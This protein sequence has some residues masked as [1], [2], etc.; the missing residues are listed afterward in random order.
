MRRPA[1]R[2][3]LRRI[4]RRSMDPGRIMRRRRRRRRSR[5]FRGMRRGDA[6]LREEEGGRLGLGLT[7]PWSYVTR[8]MHL[9]RLMTA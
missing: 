2:M 5:G 7:V 3:R 6:D 4:Y 8:V 9:L 1:T